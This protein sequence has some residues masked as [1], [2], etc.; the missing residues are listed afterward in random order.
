MPDF[1]IA[2]AMPRTSSSLT[3]QPNL[4]QVFQPI[5]GVRASP[6]DTEVDCANVAVG[7]WKEIATASVNAT[8]VN[9]KRSCFVMVRLVA[10][11][12]HTTA[13]LRLRFILRAV[14]PS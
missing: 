9:A 14:V 12:H 2:S 6:A 1:T 7:N 5:G 13:N 10:I 8:S 3:L 11:D 4:F